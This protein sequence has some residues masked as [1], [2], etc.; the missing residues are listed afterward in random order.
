MSS[1]NDAKKYPAPR[2]T[3]GT[4]FLRS[5]LPWQL[6]RFL[7]INLRMTVMIKKSHGR[8]VSDQHKGKVNW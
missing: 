2:P 1:L 6:L 5:F 8:K 3:K 4:L 7:I